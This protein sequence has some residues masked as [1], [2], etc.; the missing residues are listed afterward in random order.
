[1]ATCKLSIES[2]GDN[3][4]VDINGKGVDL[5]TAITT[6]LTGNSDIRNIIAM[7]LM[8]AAEE[9]L[10]NKGETDEQRTLN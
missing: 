4:I 5:V 9:K 8:F 3:V 1:M 2:D 6:V 10:T 7:A